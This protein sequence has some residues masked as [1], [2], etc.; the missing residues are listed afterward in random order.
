MKFSIG[1][2]LVVEVKGTVLEVK[3]RNLSVL[4]EKENGVKSI[5]TQKGV[6]QTCCRIRR[7]CVF[8]PAT[9]F[10]LSLH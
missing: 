4:G 5:A 3:V 7:S 2:T 9:P 6:S 1:Q 10:C 8:I